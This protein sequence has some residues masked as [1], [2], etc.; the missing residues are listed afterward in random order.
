MIV[1]LRRQRL[2]LRNKQKIAIDQEKQT[3]NIIRLGIVVMRGLLLQ[4]VQF[5][6]WSRNYVHFFNDFFRIPLKIRNKQLHANAYMKDI[7][8]GF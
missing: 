1:V 5:N 4:L 6:A 3:Y 8:F 2:E 7:D